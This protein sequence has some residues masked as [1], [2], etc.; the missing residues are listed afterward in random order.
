MIYIS[1]FM[2]LLFLILNQ[3]YVLI[4]IIFNIYFSCYL[5]YFLNWF[6][7]IEDYVKINIFYFD[8]VFVINQLIFFISI[9]VLVLL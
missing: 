8:L 6:F 2:Y 9:N 4:F 7:M 5:N 1:K 3:L